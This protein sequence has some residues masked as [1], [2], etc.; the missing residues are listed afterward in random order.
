M[1]AVEGLSEGERDATPGTRGA[2]EAR[3]IARRL[4]L[5]SILWES[6]DCF[7]PKALPKAQHVIPPPTPTSL[8]LYSQLTDCA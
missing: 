3:D 6:F 7:R 8:Q 2:V 5:A 4:V 1:I